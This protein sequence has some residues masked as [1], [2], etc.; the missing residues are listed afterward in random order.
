M[1][2]LAEKYYSIS[3]YA[4]VANN[5]LRF[6]DLSGG[7]ISLGGLKGLDRALNTN[8][9]GTLRSDPEAKTGLTYAIGSDGQMSYA[10]DT[11]GNVIQVGSATVRNLMISAIDNN[12]PV[13]VGAGVRSLTDGPA[14]V[15]GLSYSHIEGF[16]QG[17]H[18]LDNITMGWGMTF[19][20]E[21]GHTNVEGGLSDARGWGNIGAAETRMNTIRRELNAQGG[22]FGQRLNYEAIRLTPNGSAYVPFNSNTVNMIESGIVRTPVPSMQF[23]RIG[24]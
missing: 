8:Y 17:T 18:G 5:S 7:G 6:I 15:I 12:S 4:Y 2:P 1:D 10:K 24:R 16:I 22:N 14:N 13:T 23:V 21:L 9:T 3:P 19:M 20:H 11:N